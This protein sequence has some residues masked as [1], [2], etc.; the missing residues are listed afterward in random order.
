MATP[1]G[2][3]RQP[4]IELQECID[5]AA[6]DQADGGLILLLISMA[7]SY[8]M[9][10]VRKAVQRSGLN[11]QEQIYT[12]VNSDLVSPSACTTPMS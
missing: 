10:Q 1:Q 12:Q 2:S 8:N 3:C 4:T 7:T 5:P 9:Y 11:P 6:R